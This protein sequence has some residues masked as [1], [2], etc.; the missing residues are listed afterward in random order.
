MTP[1]LEQ[2]HKV[3]G[4]HVR[5]SQKRGVQVTDFGTLLTNVQDA[6]NDVQGIKKSTKYA[7]YARN[8]WIQVRAG[9]T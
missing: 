8:H 1:R 3:V 4:H 9:L 7:V 5:K 6:R 2:A